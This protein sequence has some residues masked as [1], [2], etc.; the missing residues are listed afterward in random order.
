MTMT[1]IPSRKTCCTHM[2][3]DLW[4]VA[5]DDDKS[6]DHDKDS[7]KRDFLYIW[8]WSS[9]NSCSGEQK[10]NPSTA[11]VLGSQWKS[12]AIC[13]V[14]AQGLQGLRAP[15]P[16]SSFSAGHPWNQLYGNASPFRRLQQQKL[17]S[18]LLRCLYCSCF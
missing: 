5:P 4:Q 6:D 11:S 2:V 18:T 1:K 9:A 16:C 17:R 14:G 10:R 7:L 8:L 13:R 15:K 12:W 3:V